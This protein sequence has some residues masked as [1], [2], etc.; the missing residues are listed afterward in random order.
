MGLVSRLRDDY[1]HGHGVGRLLRV[2]GCPL[3]CHSHAFI[4]PL[5]LPILG[6]V[7]LCLYL[8]PQQGAHFHLREDSFNKSGSFV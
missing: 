4:F 1:I 7:N 5:S 2:L 8:Q 6:A 3:P